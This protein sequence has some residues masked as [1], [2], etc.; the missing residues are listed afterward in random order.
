ML[1]GIFL[2]LGIGKNKSAN[3]KNAENVNTIVLIYVSVLPAELNRRAI[4]AANKVVDRI[5]TV[6]AANTALK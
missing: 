5:R 4:D 2:N 3:I 6:C 1:S